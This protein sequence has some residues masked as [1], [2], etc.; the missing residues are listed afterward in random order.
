MGK[1]I[2][3]AILLA[4][5]MA[6][7]RVFAK[8]AL[9]MTTSPRDA[10]T[11]NWLRYASKGALA[12]GLVLPALI[13]TFSTFVIISTGHVGVVTQFSKVEPEPLY[14]GFNLVAPWKVINQMSVQI[15]KKQG[16]FDAGSKDL[17]AVH[18]V[19]G[20]N[21]RLQAK[22]A[23]EIFRTV[24]IDF[25]SVII[26][27]A[28]LEVLKAHTATYQASDI[29]HQRA[30]LKSEVQVDLAAWLAKYGIELREVSLA[31]VSFDKGYMDAVEAKQVEEQRAQK[32]VYEVMQSQREAEKDAASALGKA[33]ATR[34]TAKGDA[35]AVRAEAQAAADALRLKGQ[36]QA[37]YNA[38]VAASLTP[39]LI[40]QQRIAAW[41]EGG[42][43]V[44]QFV[45]GSGGP[46][47]LMQ[48][49]APTAKPPAEK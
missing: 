16:K 45:T 8:M 37:E 33:N 24:G 3:A 42:S 46:G 2:F 32:K 36:A 1:L 23:P 10:T 26:S 40:E 22:T 27:L 11:A 13:I 43:Q 9:G 41:Q 15:Q 28:E 20:I 7:Y 25:E 6:A 31:D 35:D 21:Y 39:A 48:I 14:E 5:G 30:K 12:A 18:V 19:M 34:E 49:P 38:R 44:P 4:V 17:Q 47:F 29:L